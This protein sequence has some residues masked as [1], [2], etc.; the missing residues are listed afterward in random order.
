MTNKKSHMR[1]RLV[2]K[3]TT[4]DDL[5]RPIRTPLHTTKISMKIDPHYRATR[6]DD[7]AQ[8]CSMSLVS[9]N[10]RFVF[11]GVPWRGCQTTMGNRKHRFSVLSDAESSEYSP[12]SRFHWSISTWPWMTL[13]GYFT[14]NSILRGYMS[15]A[16]KSGL[17]SLTTLKLVVK[18]GEL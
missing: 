11:P 2:P 17:R 4:L 8:I 15:T 7:V 13:N 3:S 5:E 14:L 10:V 18:F 9:G 12:L 16:L 6:G 1:F